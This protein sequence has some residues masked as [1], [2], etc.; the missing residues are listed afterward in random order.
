MGVV[1]RDCRG[2]VEVAESKVMNGTYAA[3]TVEAFAVEE[4]I[5]PACQRGLNQ[6]IIESD[7]LSIVQAV[8]TNSNMGELGAIVQG[9][10]GLLRNF[11]S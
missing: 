5:L 9:I 8:N 7:S 11:G 1:I 2:M 3:E 4:G 10:T 6:V